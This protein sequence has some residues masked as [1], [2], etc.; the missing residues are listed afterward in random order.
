MEQRML[1]VMFNGN[2]VPD[3]T[4][5]S[6]QKLIS[7]G[8]VAHP[9]DVKLY[10][11]DEDDLAKIVAKSILSKHSCTKQEEFEGDRTIK[12]LVT[13]YPVRDR[14]NFTMR[15][16]IDLHDIRERMLHGKAIEDDVHFVKKLANLFKIG[17]YNPKKAISLGFD[18][19]V[20]NIT[21]KIYNKFF[22]EEGEPLR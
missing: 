4:V 15:L 12:V 20:K 8:C 13:R 3:K 9:D 21:L 11:L 19:D 18:E 2:D 17:Y 1:I 16:S 10:T 5:I 14:L 7:E 22:D 6:I